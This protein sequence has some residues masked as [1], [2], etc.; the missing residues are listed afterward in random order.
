ML[1]R[2]DSRRPRTVWEGAEILR[3]G[4]AP[5]AGLALLSG[6]ER[7]HGGKAFRID[8]VSGLQR[9]PG[10][11]PRA[12]GLDAALIAQAEFVPQ[13]AAGAHRM[14]PW[15]VMKPEEEFLRARGKI[16]PAPRRLPRIP[17]EC[18]GA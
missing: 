11:L 17:G 8:R 2:L 15:H 10:F 1:R 6:Q 3:A 16:R 14:I 7:P 4:V 9:S 18:I 13:R 12:H 5:D